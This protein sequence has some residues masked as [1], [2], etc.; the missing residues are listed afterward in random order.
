LPELIGILYKF[1]DSKFSKSAIESIS[2]SSNDAVI[3]LWLPIH[4]A[5]AWDESSRNARVLGN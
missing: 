2:I 4:P 5:N 3:L 1:Y